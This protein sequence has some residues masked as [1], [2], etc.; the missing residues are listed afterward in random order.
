MPSTPPPAPPGASTSGSRPR[1]PRVLVVEDEAEPREFLSAELVRSGF[2]VTQAGDGEEALEQLRRFRPDVVVLDLVL[3]RLS[4]FALA[5]AIRGCDAGA[6]TVIVAVSAL[7]SEA[8]R[9]EAIASGC[10]ALLTKPVHP[11]LVVEQAWRLLGRLGKEPPAEG[12]G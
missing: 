4:G 1:S 10:D 6:G 9:T 5:R 11:V 7:G 2:V 12:Q 8:L 3:P